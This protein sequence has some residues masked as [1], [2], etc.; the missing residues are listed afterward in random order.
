MHRVIHDFGLKPS[1]A[2]EFETLVA[3]WFSVMKPLKG[4]IAISLFRSTEDDGHFCAIS[5]WASEQSYEAFHVSP[6]H[7]KV[8]D[9]TDRLFT[10]QNRNAFDL[11]YEVTTREYDG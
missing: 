2:A 4:F 5:D 7:Q 3:D 11:V 6:E 8:A 10:R 9:A 1:R